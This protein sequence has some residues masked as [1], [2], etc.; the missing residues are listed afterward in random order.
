MKLLIALRCEILKTKRTSAFYLALGAAAFAPFTSLLDLALDG[1]S[2][3]DRADILNRMLVRK[4][5]MTNILTLPVFIILCGILLHQ[6]EYRNNTWKQV[7]CSPQTKANVFAAK[8]I[9]VQL[10]ILTF[11]VVNQLLMFVAVVILHFAEP[12]L[13][14]LS[15]PLNVKA[16]LITVTNAYLSLFAI[17]A[18]QF[19]LG[20][21]FRNFM[22]PLAIGIGCWFFGFILIMQSQF[23]IAAYF[24]Y[25]YHVY[26]NLPFIG[27]RFTSAIWPSLAYSAFF[28]VL[29]Y[30]DFRRRRMNA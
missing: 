7:L 18:I 8:F 4:F 10:L 21:R 12:S 23:G 3:E 16:M 17:S 24:P 20:L 26:G 5:E 22:A 2:A 13:N 29:G 15:Q 19:W 14:V 1:I 28:L 30:F 6:L 27:G 25:S 9:N 11:L